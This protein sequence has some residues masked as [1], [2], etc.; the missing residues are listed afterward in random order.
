MEAN[1]YKIFPGINELTKPDKTTADSIISYYY[2]YRLTMLQAI[3]DPYP[4]TACL[5]L[6]VSVSALS[7]ARLV[8]ITTS[9]LCCKVCSVA[10][11]IG[12]QLVIIIIIVR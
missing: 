6:S 4:Q 10:S 2:Y 8:L 7:A 5:W 9:V 1:S 3:S 12:Y 11:H